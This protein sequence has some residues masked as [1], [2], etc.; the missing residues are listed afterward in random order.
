MC[1]CVCLEEFCQRKWKSL[2]DTYLKER[3][4]ETKRKSGSGAGTGKWWKYSAVLS[5]LYPFITP[6][7]TSGNMGQGVEEDRIAESNT[8]LDAAEAEPEGMD[9]GSEAAAGPSENDLGGLLTSDDTHTAWET[10]KKNIIGVD[11]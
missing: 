4:K 11:G 8:P 5:F 10:H 1:V 6:R 9:Q 2:R 7:E 3:K